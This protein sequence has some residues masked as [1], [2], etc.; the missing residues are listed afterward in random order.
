[1]CKKKK[2]IE[3]LF[4]YKADLFNIEKNGSDEKQDHFFTY[5]KV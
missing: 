1:M 4:W 3:T 2:K 5:F